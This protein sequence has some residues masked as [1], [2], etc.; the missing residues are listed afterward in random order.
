MIIIRAF[1]VV[2]SVCLLALSGTSPAQ[3]NLTWKQLYEPGVGGRVDSI[4]VSPHS[5]Q[6]RVL[7]GGDMLGIAYSDDLANSWSQ[8]V[9]GLKGY[10]INDFTYHPTATNT[11]WAGTMS[12]A[13]KSTDGGRSWTNKVSGM[14]ASEWG[15]FTH[16]V[17]SVLIDP[18]NSNRLLALFGDR[19]YFNTGSCKNFGAVYESTDAG[20]NW[21]L[22]GRLDPGKT[23]GEVNVTTASF[24]AGSSTVVFASVSGYGVMKSTNGGA[25]WAGSNSGLPTAD[26]S[27]VAVHPA[28][29]NVLWVSLGAGKGVYKSNNQGASWAPLNG[30]GANVLD[31]A[32]TF[33]AVAVCK[34]NTNV[35]WTT[36]TDQNGQ[37]AVYRSADGGANWAKVRS[38]SVDEPYGVSMNPEQLAIDPKDDRVAFTGSPVAVY[39]TTDAGVTW[40]DVSAYQPTGSTN[41]KG[42]GY[43]GMVSTEFTWNPFNK[44]VAIANA[45]DDGK[46]M[47]SI[48]N[49]QTWKVHHANINA[50]EGGSDASFSGTGGNTIY[51]ALGDM[52]QWY[53]TGGLF[54]STNGGASWNELP[55]PANTRDVCTDVYAS[56]SN[57]NIVFA[58]FRWSGGGEALFRS[59]NGGSSWTTCPLYH[60]DGYEDWR[61]MDVVGNS[62]T[63]TPSVY[64]A[65][66]YHG[67]YRSTDGGVTWSYIGGNASGDWGN[68]TLAI[69]PKDPSVIYTA[70]F[71][72]GSWYDGVARWNGSGWSRLAGGDGTPFQIWNISDVVV[73]PNNS[74]RLVATTNENPF[75]DLSDSSGVWLSDDRGVTWRQQ[76]AGLGMLRANCVS[77]SPDSS[78]I[79]VGANGGGF[80][81]ADLGATGLSATYY[82]NINFTGATLSRTDETL[83]FDWG[84]GSPDPAI[85]ADTF[86][87]RWQG[88]VLANTAGSYRFATWSDDGIR[89]WVGG[90]LVIDNWT[91]HSPT[92]NESANIT[93][94][95]NEKKSIVVEFFENG[96]G[97]TCQLQWLKAGAAA[98]EVVPKTQLCPV[99][100][101]LSAT[102]FDNMDFTGATVTRVDT[103][104]DFDWSSGSPHANIASD[105]FSARWQGQVQAPA[106]GNLRFGTWSDDGIRVWVGNTLVIDNWTNHAPTWNESA[107]IAFAA[108]EKK[109]IKVE[110]FENGG[111]ATCRLQWLPPGA[112]AW[113]TV[114]K[115]GLF[116]N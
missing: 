110:F 99:S 43:S 11:I 14:P 1:P 112:S 94:A 21:T 59:S 76:N 106:A 87:V 53:A 47:L 67:T 71:G 85:G 95:T 26:V 64:Y 75:D 22:K 72:G 12:G 83:N 36:A 29:V 38:G 102:Y 28:N 15:K 39:R 35:L 69:D 4:A 77:F 48:D 60:P 30:S 46:L 34:A 44:S 8:Q 105:T 52:D 65:A 9:T 93:F 24:A 62:L 92:W 2:A 91:N 58:V 61:V 41:W 45:M 40:K 19:R 98:W 33:T 27:G 89:V 51:A 23:G 50:Y 20:E 108:G 42:T 114:P 100:P 49:L 101:G 107:N 96:G 68:I 31:Q 6:N 13:Y 86:S 79:V 10:E 17:N 115:E 18:N 54:K 37:G 16:S 90:A 78:Q 103:T 81:I 113:T 56:P 109:S 111:G 25:T 66:A 32:G 7:S 97:A 5:G 57:P 3:T 82:D 73:D 84:G 104:V 63:G 88:Q 116:S 74:N 55:R 80:Y 70:N